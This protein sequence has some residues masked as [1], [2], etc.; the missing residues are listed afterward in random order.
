MMSARAVRPSFRSVLS[1]GRDS[2][3]LTSDPCRFMDQLAL[4]DPTVCAHLR[5]QGVN[6]HFFAFRWM[7]VLFA[8]D[9]D[10]LGDVL[11]VWDS[12]FGDSEGCKAAT[13]RVCCALVLVHTPHPS[14]CLSALCHVQ[15]CHASLSCDGHQAEPQTC[16]TS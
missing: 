2:K 12:L 3:T 6:P 11:R 5:E 9:I 15:F 16:I 14:F 10:A 7:T 4:A 13:M 8:Q 1:T